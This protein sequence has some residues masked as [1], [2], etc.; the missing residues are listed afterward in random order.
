[1]APLAPFRVHLRVRRESPLELSDSFKA[2]SQNSPFET[3]WKFGI[4]P[5]WGLRE[6]TRGVEK[7]TI[8]ASLAASEAR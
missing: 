1:M 8:R 5:E 3:V 2:K 7:V 4:G 6:R